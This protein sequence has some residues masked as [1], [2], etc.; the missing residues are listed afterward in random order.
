VTKQLKQLIKELSINNLEALLVTDETNVSYLTGFTSHDSWLLISKQGS[1]YITD[2][3]YIDEVRSKLKNIYLQ[4]INGSIFKTVVNLAKKL[5]VK[6]LGF[7]SKHLSQAEY[8]FI[9]KYLSKSIKFI[10]TFDY[11]EILRQI[12]SDEELKKVKQAITLTKQAF[13]FLK[14]TIKIGVKESAVEIALSN[15]LKSKGCS[16]AFEP[17]IASGKNSALPHAPI[18]KKTIA[19]KEPIVVDIGID[20]LGYKS[21]LTRVYFLG[22]IPS[23]VSN[24]YNIVLEAQE[25][26]INKIKAGV[27]ISEIDRVA[28]NYIKSKGLGK[29]FGHALGHGVGRNTHEIPSISSKNKSELTAGMI[30]T[31]EPAVYISNK[32]G[33][34][35]ED[36]VLVTDNGCEVL[37]ANINKPN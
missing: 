15:F 30:I 9:K 18:T 19:E 8:V 29:Y 4:K 36:M 3:R 14:K 28:R 20:F 23:V 21:D 10:S 11:V 25:K 33:I 32:F 26:A 16:Y 27:P 37:S 34:R 24:I 12:K 31:V 17:I 1:Y 22:K 6:K 2:F 35:L 5:K 7:E 13:A